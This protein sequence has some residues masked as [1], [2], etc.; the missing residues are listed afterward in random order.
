MKDSKDKNPKGF[1]K[2]NQYWTFRNKHGRNHIYTPEALW[3]EAIKYFEWMSERVWNKKE[4]IK[5]GEYAGT[6]VDVPTSTPMSLESFTLFADISME[7]FRNYEKTNDFIDVTTRIRTVIESQQL[8]GATV[9]AYNPNIIAR[10]L[11]LVEKVEQK[12]T[13]KMGIDE[14]FVD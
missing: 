4:A 2:G 1:P 10:K 11:G 13:L 7:T 14:E 8:E 12:T 6:L 5:S 3:D 9:G